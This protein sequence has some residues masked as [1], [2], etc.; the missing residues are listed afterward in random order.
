MDPTYSNQQ[1]ISIYFEIGLRNGHFTAIFRKM[2]NT[3]LT[4]I[5]KA[6]SDTIRLHILRLLKRDSLAANEL[7]QI[8][9]IKQSALSHHL[10]VMTQASWLCTRREGNTLFYRRSASL[11]KDM[12]SVQTSIL[13]SLDKQPLEAQLD[14]QLQNIRQARQQIGAAFFESHAN[15]LDSV[16]DRIAGFKHYSDAIQEALK[17][18]PLQGY[19]SAMEIGPGDGGFLPFLSNAFKKVYALD[20]ALPMLELAKEQVQDLNNIEFIHGDIQSALDAKITPDFLALNMVLHHI[21]SPADF[22]AQCWQ[23]L[24]DDG[25]LLITDLCTHQQDWVREACGDFWLGFE[26]DELLSWAKNIG[27]KT[28]APVFVGLKNGFQIQIH[29]LKKSN[30][31]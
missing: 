17:L 23:T 13:S 3:D 24:S 10:K 18:N 12:A 14:S 15:E 27:F 19:A 26:P 30:G 25:C 16:T 8:L 2:L 29:L 4:Q 21:A 1:P 20:I 7:A 9:S 31:E 22:L 28:Q 6:S 11:D 5:L